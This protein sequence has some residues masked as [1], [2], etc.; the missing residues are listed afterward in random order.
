METFKD[1]LK[2]WG[3]TLLEFWGRLSLNQKVLFA[4]AALLLVLAVVVVSA[5]SGTAYDTLYT[6][7][8]A[9][10]TSAVVAKLDEYKVAYKL[11]DNGDEG[12]TILVP[13]DVKDKTRIKLA[14]D[15]LPSNQSGLE[16]FQT[17]NF[18]ETESDKKVK[19]QMALQGELARTIQAL[20]EVKAAKVNLALPEETLFSD[21]EQ[22]PKASVVINTNN[23]QTLNTQEVHAIVNLVANSVTGLD[24]QD[25]VIVDQNGNLLSDNIDSDDAVSNGQV[26]MQMAMKREFEREKQLAIQSMLD[27]T[28]GADNAVVRVNAELNFSNTEQ[29]TEQYFNDKDGAHVRS[30]TSQ[31]ESSTNTQPGASG[32]P[33]TD[34]NVPQYSQTGTGSAASSED[35]SSKTTNYE[36]SKTETDTQ[37]PPGEVKYDYLTVSV[38]VNNKAVK[39]VNLGSTEAERAATIRNMVATAT[40]LRENRQNENVSLNSNISVAFMDFAPAAEPAQNKPGFLDK[41]LASPITPALLVVIAAIIVALAI[42]AKKKAAAIPKT[43]ETDEGELD[44]AV[45][46]EINIE[47]IFERNLTPEEKENLKIKEEID[48]LVETDP[49]SAVQ[50]LKSWMSED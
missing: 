13:A 31:K 46:D 42:R 47:D 6:L 37:I 39:D 17:T 45:D 26:K 38:I 32:T 48:K 5:G 9:K 33:G 18:G 1:R 35:K 50:V 29:K 10:D 40:G 36:I 25:V 30:E 3:K 14:G 4:G 22:K 20:D 12:T 49:E 28:L 34:S 15:N 23:G 7:K 24:K 43:D 44:I 8:N 11:Q 19:Y 21:K 41:T 2:Q 16:L 27:K